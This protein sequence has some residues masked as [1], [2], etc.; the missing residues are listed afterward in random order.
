MTQIMQGYAAEKHSGKWV[1]S[2]ATKD[3]DGVFC[4]SGNATWKMRI[5]GR[6]CHT[7]EEAETFCKE[8]NE[9][10]WL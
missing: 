10:L 2:P 7:L 4:H 9:G 8:M 1:Y 6:F 5:T 3:E